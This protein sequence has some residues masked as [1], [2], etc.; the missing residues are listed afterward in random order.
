MHIFVF[1]LVGLFF[2]SFLGRKKSLVSNTTTLK[3]NKRGQSQWPILY[4]LHRVFYP[5][6]EVKNS[7]FPISMLLD[8][9]LLGR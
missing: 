7:S 3:L 4:L 6:L 2:M 5:I 8:A 9:I 1:S